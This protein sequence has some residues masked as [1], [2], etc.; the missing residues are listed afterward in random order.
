M[1]GL[2]LRGGLSDL[3]VG[4]LVRGRAG[5]GVRPKIWEPIE[6]GGAGG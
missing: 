6:E 1:G 3:V 4:V 5:W 2:D